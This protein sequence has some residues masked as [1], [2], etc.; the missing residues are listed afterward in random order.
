MYQSVAP[1]TTSNAPLNSFV[2]SEVSVEKLTEMDQA[3]VIEFLSRRPIHTVTMLGFISDNGL[4][5]PLNRGT[6]YSCRNRNGQLEGVALIGHATLMETTTDRALEA[7]AD[8]AKKCD[9]AHMIMGESERVNSFW[10]QY[11]DGGQDMR[12]ACRE[13]L[14]ELQ[15]PVQVRDS[16]PGLRPATLE[17]LELVMPVQAQMAFQESGLNPFEKDAKGFRERCARRIGRGRTWVVVENGTLLFKA[18]LISE[19]DAVAYL[20]GIWV[21][22]ENRGQN[23]GL[24]CISQLSRTLLT[25]KNS[26]CLLVNEKN[27]SAHDFYKRAGFKLHAT[28][29]S[30]FLS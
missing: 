20:E 23:I 14:F 11:E 3:E 12:L 9:T 10:Q 16:V 13:L 18:E 29:D 26:I 15:W 6:F 4:V 21:N 1:K 27:K 2:S 28:Y 22:P 17:D 24:R 19:T 7:F 25:K 8:I 30:I 5:N